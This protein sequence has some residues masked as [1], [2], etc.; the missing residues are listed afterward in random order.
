MYIHPQTRFC[1]NDRSLLSHYRLIQKKPFSPHL[2][3]RCFDIDLLLISSREF[4]GIDQVTELRV[5]GEVRYQVLALLEQ[6]I[7]Y[8]P[9]KDG[10][11]SGAQMRTIASIQVVCGSVV[12]AN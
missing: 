9:T 4:P 3:Q 7:Q 6:H 5:L 1:C 8:H 2:N 10:L 11:P 12:F